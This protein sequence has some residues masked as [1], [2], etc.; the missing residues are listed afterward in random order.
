V[1]LT[2]SFPPHPS[3]DILEEYAFGRLPDALIDQVEEHLLI[4]HTCQDVVEETGGFISAMKSANTHPIPVAGLLAAGWRRAAPGASVAAVLA[5]VIVAVVVLGVRKP[6]LGSPPTPVNVSLSSLRGFDA[7]SPAP[8]GRP[9]QLV[10]DAPGLTPGK[11]YQ[12]ELVDA[13]GREVWKGAV[14]ETDGKLAATMTQPLSAGVYWVRLY[15]RDSEL[16]REFGMS[17]N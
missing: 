7:M 1:D 3:E 6:T 4:C 10:I 14:T 12:V 5:V 9:L 11:Q 13:A 2:K 17:V 15:G 16:V 8:A